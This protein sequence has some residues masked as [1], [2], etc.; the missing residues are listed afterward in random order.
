MAGRGIV[1]L[2]A[3]MLAAACGDQDDSQPTVDDDSP[4][5]AAPQTSAPDQPDEPDD[6]MTIEEPTDDAE[7]SA[8]GAQGPAPLDYE[9]TMRR[10]EQLAAET[11]YAQALR[12]CRRLRQQYRSGERWRAV[13]AKLMSLTNAHRQAVGLDYAIQRLGPDNP[14]AARDAAAGQLL[15]AGQVGQ[16]FLRKA[17]RDAQSPGT[18]AAAVDLLVEVGTQADAALFVDRLEQLPDEPLRGVLARAVTERAGQLDLGNLVKLVALRDARALG[19]YHEL[20]DEAVQHAAGNRFDP[21]SLQALSRGVLENRDFALLNQGRALGLIY[22]HGA[23]RNEQAFNAMFPDDDPLDPLRAWVTRAR[24]ASVPSI[25][26]EAEQVHLLLLAFNFERLR[27]GLVAWWGFDEKLETGVTDVTGQGRDAKVIG[28]APAQTEGVIGKAVVFASDNRGVESK[29]TQ[30]HL[31]GKLHQSSYSFAAWVKPDAVPKNKQPDRHWAI[32]N[33]EGWHQG[34][35][36]THEGRFQGVQYPAAEQSVAISASTKARVG[37]WQ[38]VVFSVD[39]TQRR[40]TLYV[41]GAQAGRKSLPDKAGFWD[42]YDGQPVRVGLARF[43]PKDWAYRFS[44]AID[45]VA[46]YSRALTQEDA[47][48]LAR[49]ESRSIRDRLA[50][51]ER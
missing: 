11:K 3:T 23:G 9:Q 1:M 13:S 46:I 12:L 43:G 15:A 31:F 5:A 21:E 33:K 10:I 8:D 40:L 7:D 37:Q 49:I 35:F 32:V 50:I 39:L 4:A 45:E 26:D 27:R 2:V 25:A 47:Q 17:V 30:D 14:P 48:A 19:D 28:A 24:S 44:G 41:D 22:A 6:P 29:P 38:H 42:R 51:P 20:L 16:T 36:L 18:A 34:L